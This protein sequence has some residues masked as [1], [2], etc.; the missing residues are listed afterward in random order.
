MLRTIFCSIA[1]LATCAGTLV[2]DDTKGQNAKGESG[3][4]AMFV[5]A[6]TVKNTITFQANDKTGKNPE[7]TMPLAK[8][9]KI[10]GKDNKPETLTIFVQ[11][12]QKQKNKSILVV[13]DKGGKQI[14]E[15]KELS[16]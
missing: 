1:T 5:K 3:L 11:D 7:M 15:I 13:K 6:D 10:L 4:Q 14:V 12:M 8:D 2:A 9:A 16:N